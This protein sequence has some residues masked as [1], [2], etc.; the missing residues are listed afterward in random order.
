MFTFLEDRVAQINLDPSMTEI[1]MVFN[2][3]S[4]KASLCILTISVFTFLEDRVAQ[5]N[6]DPSMTEIVTVFKD[7]R[8]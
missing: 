1:V 8:C 5:I 3:Y 2:H 4:F 7:Y 6:L